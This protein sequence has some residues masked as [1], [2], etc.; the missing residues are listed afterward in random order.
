MWMIFQFQ[1]FLI[2][3]VYTPLCVVAFST[4]Q[5]VYI[6]DFSSVNTCQLH[7]ILQIK[8]IKVHLFIKFEIKK[9]LNLYP[10]DDIV[11]P[12]QNFGEVQLYF[13]V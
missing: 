10:S 5:S 8:N 4:F 7:F 3:S 9:C 6:S 1:I 12:R 13:S 2:D 11:T